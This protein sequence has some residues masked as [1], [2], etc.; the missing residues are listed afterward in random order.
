MGAACLSMWNVHIWGAHKLLTK[1]TQKTV[2]VCFNGLHVATCSSSSLF[3]PSIWGDKHHQWERYTLS[4]FRRVT[5]SLLL[6]QPQ[7]YCLAMPQQSHQ[8]SQCHPSSSL[9]TVTKSLQHAQ[10]TKSGVLT[11]NWA[12]ASGRNWPNSDSKSSWFWNSL[13][14]CKTI[15]R[16]RTQ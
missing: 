13:E 16:W 4:H 11:E 5:L 3:T 14:T 6:C 10:G 9:P 7:H 2:A 1:R 8:H 15:K 12:V